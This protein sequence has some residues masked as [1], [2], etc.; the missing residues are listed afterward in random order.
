M[1]RD[2]SEAL[3]QAMEFYIAGQLVEAKA[4]LLDIVRSDPNVEAGWMF[5]SYTLE[6]PAQKADCLRKVLAINPQNAEAKVTLEELEGA[7]NPAPAAVRSPS[8]LPHANPFTVD[9]DHAND[10]IPAITDERFPGTSSPATPAQPLASASF[11]E[12]AKVVPLASTASSQPPEIPVPAEKASF[13]PAPVEHEP[14]AAP[15]V[16]RV[17]PP[18]SAPIPPHPAAVQPPVHPVQPSAFPN[19]QPAVTQKAAMSGAPQPASA[20]K[21]KTGQLAATVEHP[22]AKAGP[23][24]P[25]SAEKEPAKERGNLGCIYLMAGIAVLFIA[26]AVCFGLYRTGYLS[27]MLPFPAFGNPGASVDAPNGVNPPIV[28]DTPTTWAL[29]PRATETPTPTLTRTPTITATPTLNPTPTLAPPDATVEADMARVRKEVEDIRGLKLVGTVPAYVVDR[30]QAEEILQADLDR[31]NYRETI[32][33]E[34]KA[35]AALGFIKPTYDLAKFAT[36]RLADGVLGFYMPSTRTMYVIGNRFA[37]MERYTFSHE[38]DHAIV[39]SI[40][41]DSMANYGDPLCANDSQ[42]CEAIRALVEGDAM[43]VMTLWYDQYATAYD[44][45]DIDLSPSQLMMPPEQNTPAYM[46]PSMVFTYLGGM[47][48]V[49][50]LWEKGNWALVN[51]AFEKLPYSTEQI[52]HPEKYLAGEKPIPMNVPDLSNAVGSGWTLI[53]SDSLG[54]YM[55]YL[56]LA[57]GADNPAQLDSNTAAAAAVGWGGDHYLVFASADGERSLLA[58]EWTWDTD[59]DASEF[60]A[61]MQAYLEK[62]FRGETATATAGKCWTMND[63]S[64]CIYRAGKNILWISAPE[65]GTVDSIRLAYGRY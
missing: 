43:L 50:T 8:E 2:F 6:D 38:Y 20:L 45:R 33:N 35:L 4:L 14:V 58:A 62:R 7:H 3:Q 59:A 17:P 27:G 53:K 41:P 36:Q 54:E 25:P 49:Q 37:G 56:L 26:G 9:I 57:Y 42:R 61:A 5:L 24:Q 28:L 44:R 23:S 48:F 52:L 15:P 31:I 16:V 47:N 55:T 34:A 21:P 18:S 40:Y 13:P 22:P 46:Y 51:K 10:E 39:H 11:Q 19:K 1:A 60:M 32:K 29:P 12:A 64:A 30:T 65:M 63:T